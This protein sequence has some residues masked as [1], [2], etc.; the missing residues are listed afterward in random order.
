MIHTWYK[1]DSVRI[2]ARTRQVI[3][4]TF[5]ANRFN[6]T[7]ARFQRPLA[8]VNIP[9]FVG[10]CR[11]ETVTSTE[12]I[13]RPSVTDLKEL[14]EEKKDQWFGALAFYKNPTRFMI[15]SLTVSICSTVPIFILPGGF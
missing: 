13:R 8:G 11:K 1:Q 5:P 12:G 9:H 3:Q 2:E 15:A 6:V 14:T 4:K 10:C 7:F